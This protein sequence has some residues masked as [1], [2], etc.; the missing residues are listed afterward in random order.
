[1]K[2]PSL[3][4]VFALLLAVATGCG[5]SPGE[6][7]LVLWH[8]YSGA[9]LAALEETVASVEA[10]SALAIKLVSVP[11]EAFADKLTNAIPNGNGPDLFIIANDR[12][13]HWASAR[14]IEP[15]EFWVDE[16][17]A[18]RFTGD[19]LAAMA[20]G[21]SLYGLPLAAKSVALFYRSDLVETAPQTTDELI[22]MAGEL[23]NA[24]AYPLAYENTTLYGHAAWLHGFGGEIFAPSGALQIVTPEAIRALEFA[25][26]LDSEDIVPAGVDGRMVATLFNEG[27]AAMAIS[28]PWFLADIDAEVPWRVT[29]LPTVS[30]TG[31]PARPYLGVEGVLMSARARDKRL[32][33]RA[34]D[35][36]ASDA[37]AVRRARLARQVVANPAAYES[38]ELRAD[39]LLQAFRAQ[40]ERSVPM[41]TATAMRSVWTPYQSALLR[42]LEQGADPERS[43]R[44]AAAE[45]E[46][47]RGSAP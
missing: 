20:T 7:E 15:I 11:Y 38:T 43:L 1:M 40:L 8:A 24:G 44:A 35:A 31:L 28:G 25:R 29:T 27:K 42:V 36:L 33:F 19:A 4:L 45:I 23:R 3:A 17:L 22:A 18:G 30:A 10:E 47:F 26:R 2:L 5:Q 41:P 32:A 14:L 16:G 12:I 6:E 34:M 46:S 9:E 37:N 13:G 39:P 21:G